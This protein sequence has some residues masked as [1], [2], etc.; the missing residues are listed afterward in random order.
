MTFKRDQGADVDGDGA[1]PARRMRLT[2][3]SMSL[4]RIMGSPYRRRAPRCHVTAM[5]WMTG[6]GRSR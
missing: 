1:A 4:V 6:P 3:A 5:Y 2:V